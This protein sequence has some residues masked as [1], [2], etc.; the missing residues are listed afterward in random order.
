MA[1]KKLHKRLMGNE[2]FLAN[3]ARV[4]EFILFDVATDGSN[5]LVQDGGD[6]FYGVENEVDGHLIPKVCL[7]NWIS[8]EC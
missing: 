3:E 1:I 4:S 7:I 5:V 8:L 6:L 2:I